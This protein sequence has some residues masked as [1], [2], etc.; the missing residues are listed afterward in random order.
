MPKGFNR[1]DFDMLDASDDDAMPSRFGT[2]S[3]V[4]IKSILN[5][6]NNPDDVWSQSYASIRKVNILL[7]QINIVPVPA[8]IPFWKA[9]SR[10]LRALFY[11]EL[12]K[13]YGGVPLIGDSVYNPTDVIRM[14]RNTFADCITYIAAECDSIKGKLKAEP[15][16]AGDWGKASRGAAMALKAKVLLYAASPLFNGGVPAGASS[17]LQNVMGYPTYDVNR[18]TLAANAANDLL[19]L[20]VYSLEPT[21]NNV[22]LNRQ[23]KEVIISYLRGTTTD[24]ET[25]NGPVGYGTSAAGYGNTSPTEDLVDAFP[26]LN[27]KAITDPT[28]GY[29]PTNPYNNRDPRLA[30]TVMYNNLQW[31]NRGVQTYEGGQDKPNIGSR[32]QTQTGYY[33]RKF[34]GNFATSTAYSAQNHNFPIL[35]IAET[36]LDYAEALNEAS[37]TPPAAVYTTLINIRKRAG[38]TAG[39]D[40]KY[41]L[42]TITTQAQ[43][44]DAIRNE[45][46]IEMAF[47]EQRFYDLRRWK[48]AETALNKN[49]SGMRITKTSTGT[50]IYTPFAAEAITFAFPKMYLYPIPFSE[51]TQNP[52]LIQNFA[53]DTTGYLQNISIYEKD[54]PTNG[55]VTNEKGQFQITLR[56][57][58]ILVISS[59]GY[60]DQEV[61]A[62]SYLNKP[63]IVTLASASKDLDD[64]VVIGYGTKKKITN[65]GAVNAIAGDEIRETPT[66]SVQNTLSGRVPGIFSQQ[67]SGQPGG[68]G[69][70]L[71]IRGVSTITNDPNNA[72]AQPLLIVDDMEYGGYLSDLDADQIESLTILKDASTTAVYGVKG[73]NGVIVITTRRGKIGRPQVSLRSE[74]GF[75]SPTMT[76]KFLGS[77]QAATLRNQAYAN[78]GSAPFFT[79]ADIQA[80][81][82]GSDPYG[83]PDINWMK[84]LIRPYSAQSNSVL[85]IT[86]G[87]DKVK[88]FVSATYLYQNGMVKD[89][90]IN[91]D[92]N[93]NYYYKRY[94]FRSNIDLQATKTLSL[95]FDLSGDITEMNQ[96]NIDG[97]NNRDKVLFEI[98]DQAQL[99]PYAYQPYNPNGTLGANPTFF[100]TYSNNVIGRF[101]YSGYKRNYGNNVTANI[102]GTQKLDFVTRGLSLKVVVGYNSLF[103]FNRN[104]GLNGGADQFPA[105]GYNATTHVYTPFNP[106]VYEI[107]QYNL[108][109]STN[110]SNKNLT[111]QGSVNY[112]RT[113]NGNHVYGLVLFQQISKTNF[114]AV[115]GTQT[116]NVPIIDR[117]FV[118]RFGYDYKQKYLIEFD[119]AYNGSS[120]FSS[121]KRYALFPAVSAGWNIAKE[122]FVMENLRFI[123]VFKLRGSYGLTGSNNLPIDPATGLP[124]LYVY[125]QNYTNSG[126]YS[127]G[128]VSNNITGIIE[129]T[130]GTNVTWEKEKQADYGVDIKMFNN[131]LGIT[132]DYFDKERYDILIRRGS[133]STVLGVGVPPVNLGKVSNKGFEVE[134]SYAGNITKKLTYSVRGNISYAK[135]KILYQDEAQPAYPYL[136]GTGHSVGYLIGYTNIGFYADSTDIAN[137]PKTPI[138]AKPGDLKYADLNKDGK[139]DPNDERV[140][141]YT[142]LPNTNLG[143]TGTLGYKGFSFSFTLQSALNF[144]M[145]RNLTG[146]YTTERLDSWS[147][148]NNIHPLLPRLSIAASVSDYDSDFWFRRMDYLRLKTVILGYQIPAKTV[149]RLSL[150]GARVYVSGYNLLT[151]MLKGKNIY[152]F[153]PEAPTSTEGGEYPVQ[154]VIFLFFIIALLATGLYSCQKSAL[155]P[156]VTPLNEAATFSDSAKTMQF[157]LAIYGDIS[158]EFGYKRYTY[159]SNISAGTE[160][161]CDEAVHRLNGPT[162]PFVYLFNGT[163]SAS[164][165]DPYTYMWTIPYTDIRRVNVYL[166]QVNHA[167]ISDALKQRTK[168]EARFLRAWYYAG[169]LK[170][171][172]GIPVIGDTVYSASDIIMPPRATYETT[173]NYILSEC[174][175]AAALLPT[176]YGANDYGRITQGACLGLKSRVLL[177]AASPLFN[178]GSVATDANVI[179]LTAYPSAD[180][181]RW[182][183]AADAAKAIIDQGLYS[184]NVDNTTAPGYGFSRVFLT[185]VNSEYLLP[186]ML[187]P[188]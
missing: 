186:G 48:L 117:G 101:E 168:A 159:A 37:A 164:I 157:L 137:N 103:S 85:N 118:G 127:I 23:N 24:L 167:P 19:T 90:T 92:L 147:P 140:Q 13:R 170:N 134:V 155:D 51:T 88:Y 68:D 187:P 153:D 154:K 96:P 30:N 21:Y 54:V 71:L 47:E 34:L 112:D 45:R 151:F 125:Q 130:L 76:P 12:V 91:P 105:Y 57:K 106:N 7:A 77:Y 4:F 52:N 86:G 35:R 53:K 150:N 123:D 185:R 22:F 87:T 181:T 72:S 15:L 104:L 174:D 38:I 49:L 132:A 100:G 64:V 62:N 29:D 16:A 113:F 80:F 177:Y 33:M 70:T 119:A 50:F 1:I 143:F 17:D 98:N 18:W 133:V 25:N 43:M 114:V 89:F 165:P 97:R 122:K 142:N 74:T 60:K 3:Q 36:M 8:Q 138:A 58:G 26:M 2:N 173:V 145:R 39:T 172:G 131:K 135:N 27:G 188:E 121:D 20:N 79:A 126:S 166:Q 65:T 40:S 120:V 63:L 115:N 111:Y 59:V 180:P 28:S 162:Q 141:K 11:F 66:A 93:S 182:Q 61:N 116:S 9:E 32:V 136:A 14:K 161:G 176:A 178:G 128:N 183:K 73:A 152:D 10:W 67:R 31:L 56:G 163:L 69:S 107:G 83:H 171:F 148:T 175:A 95:G 41:G 81:K 6:V 184:L 75:Q 5:N 42:G 102:R 124:F 139:I 110:N 78:D 144:V 55:T 108:S 179:P 46:R 146:N 99:P 84:L 158:Y 44:R 156:Q 169:L 109:Y 149:K 129:G 160:E 82:D 94:N